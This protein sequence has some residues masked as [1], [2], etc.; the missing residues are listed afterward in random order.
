MVPNGPLCDNIFKPLNKKAPRVEYPTQVSS[1]FNSQST[2]IV[3]LVENASIREYMWPRG[4]LSGV[5]FNR[6]I[7]FLSSQ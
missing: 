3:E 7:Y 5:G 6:Y 2:L 4:S 1:R